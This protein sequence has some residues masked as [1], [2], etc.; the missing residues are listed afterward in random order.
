MR[1]EVE[2]KLPDETVYTKIQTIAVTQPSYDNHVYQATDVITN[3]PAGP[4]SYRIRQVI[5]TTATG[6]AAFYI[7]SATV[8]L[9]SATPVTDIILNEKMVQLFPNPA[10][11]NI[12][13]KLTEQQSFE[14]MTIQ[15]FSQSGQLIST[16]QFN[17]PAG[18]FIKTISVNKLQSGNYIL[19][20]LKDGKPYA[21][22]EFVKQ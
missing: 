13:I 4:V 9:S 22:R 20:L 16:E 8:I 17:K 11:S 7:D 5:D 19:R 1:Y 12:R 21:S 14:K 10:S 2:R 3:S 6:F 15:V 18:E